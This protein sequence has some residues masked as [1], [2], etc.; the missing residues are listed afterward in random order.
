MGNCTYTG[1]QYKGGSLTLP[2]PC[3]QRQN[4]ASEYGN[5]N[6]IP[7]G[8]IDP[9]ALAIQK[10]V[11]TTA[12]YPAS[13]ASYAVN[14]FSLLGPAST[15]PFLKW[16]GRWDTDLAANNRLTLTETESDNPAFNAAIFCPLNCQN[17]D[18]S[19]D[20]AA[21]SDVWTITPHV[22][23]E[24][25]MGF[26][27]QL[28]FFVPQSANHNYQSTLDLP[29]LQAD[30]FPGIGINGFYGPG[31][32]SHSI[33]KEF[34][35]GAHFEL[36][37]VLNTSQD[38]VVKKEAEQE[39]R[40]AVAENPQDER[41]IC[42]L[43]EIAETKEDTQQAYDDYSKAMALQ[44][45]DADAK[46]GLAKVLIEMDQPDKALLL[47]ESSAQL[48]PTNSAVHYRLTT[49]YRKMGRVDDA[50]REIQQYQKYKEMKEKLRAVYKELQIQPAEIRADDNLEEA[51]SEKK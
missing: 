4:F 8:M 23:N 7:S 36:A 46:L 27:D 19:R 20:N 49:L 48:E 22:I 28:N 12:G 50:K 41:A 16:F 17:G 37:E 6:K 21:I 29:L 2:A 13:V 14:N 30:V 33:Y 9:A 34:V 35:F 51:P 15:N 11:M 32:A 18:V 45:G 24:A 43:A 47:L 5:G 3:L 31:S 44:A 10:Y 25:R 38:P 1:P 26:T 40:T 42:E 39:F